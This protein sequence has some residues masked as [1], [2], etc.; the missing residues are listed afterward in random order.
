LNDIEL[1]HRLGLI[2]EHEQRP[3][4]D[5]A[6]IGRLCDE[7]AE[8]VGIE[9]PLIVQEYLASFEQRRSDAVFA[10]AQRSELVRYLRGS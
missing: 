8:D 9:A 10:H 7:L 6:V 5:W 3:D 1:K 4:A 2:A